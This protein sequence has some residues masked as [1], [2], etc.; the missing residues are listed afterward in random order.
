V[1]SFLIIGDPLTDCL[2]HGLRDMEHLSLPS[3][4]EGKVKT[5][6]KLASGAFAARLTT[7]PL[8]GDDAATEERLLVKDLGQAGPSPPLWI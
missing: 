3:Y 1:P 6:V 5:S 2:F 7:S 4:P 8:H